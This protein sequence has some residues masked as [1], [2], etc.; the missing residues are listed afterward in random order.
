MNAPSPVGKHA[1]AYP[2]PPSPGDAPTG[3]AACAGRIPADSQQETLRNLDCRIFLCGDYSPGPHTRRLAAGNFK[4][5]GLSHI[6]LRR[7]Q[8]RAA[9]PQTR[10][11]ARAAPPHPSPTLTL[12]NRP[13][14][15]G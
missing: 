6:S 14:P 3:P 12:P 1:L 13:T 8:P 11:E 2:P 10:S 4:E 9:Y 7:L 5:S 15:P